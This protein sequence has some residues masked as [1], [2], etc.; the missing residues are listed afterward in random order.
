MLISRQV[1]RDIFPMKKRKQEKTNQ[2]AENQL[3]IDNNVSR[4]KQKPL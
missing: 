3:K 1:F 4:M 2:K